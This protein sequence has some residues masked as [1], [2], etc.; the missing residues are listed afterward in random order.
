MR[1]CPAYDELQ[2]AVA[3]ATSG[4]H[5]ERVL[6]L[7]VGMGQTSRRM[8]DLTQRRLVGI[9]ES[10][11]MLA[12]ASADVAADLRVSRFQDPLPEGNFKLV[13]SASVRPA[14]VGRRAGEE[15]LT[16]YSSAD[17]PASSH[18]CPTFG[19]WPRVNSRRDP[20]AQKRTALLQPK[21]MSIG[22]ELGT[23]VT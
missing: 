21:L 10:A 2:Y 20:T 5:T 8:L 3:D 14:G 4:I 15:D 19:S 13:V 1:K 18:Q 23:D 7:G 11:E 9:D 12:A 16:T 6:E 22:H 17:R